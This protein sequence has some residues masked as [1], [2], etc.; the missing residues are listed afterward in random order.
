ML[1]LMLVDEEGGEGGC[2]VSKLV[3]HLGRHLSTCV[4]SS[5]KGGITGAEMR[6]ESFVT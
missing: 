2:D 6:N 4:Y 5:I 1:D 3:V